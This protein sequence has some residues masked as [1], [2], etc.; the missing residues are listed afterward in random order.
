MM[1]QFTM[2]RIPFVVTVRPRDYFLE[3]REKVKYRVS[4]H[5][6]VV[7]AGHAREYHH[8]PTET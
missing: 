1:V 5:H 8:A 6:V 3:G 7:N 4:Y 2:V